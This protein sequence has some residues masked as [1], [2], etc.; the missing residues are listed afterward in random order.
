MFYY[1]YVLK[2]AADGNFYVG[3]TNDLKRRVAEH[4]NG[5]VHSTAARRPLELVYYEACRNQSD[6]SKREKY[7]KSAWGKRYIKSRLARYLTG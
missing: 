1:V 2:S 5:L 6:A 7:L 3:F 4:N